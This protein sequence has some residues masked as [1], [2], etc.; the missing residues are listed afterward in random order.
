M[1]RKRISK[2][3]ANLL[4]SISVAVTSTIVMSA[5]FLCLSSFLKIDAQT[6]D[7]PWIFMGIGFLC[8]ALRQICYIYRA[9]NKSMK[10]DRI[11]NASVM[12]ILGL[13]NLIFQESPIVLTISTLVYLTT[14]IG[15]VALK[16][17]YHHTFSDIIFTLL[18][19][20]ILVLLFIASCASFK[21][22]QL[23]TAVTV[24]CIL[25]SLFSLTSII[26]EAF[27]KIQLSTIKNIIKKTFAGEILIGLVFLVVSFSFVFVVSE[28]MKFT[29]ALW[30]CFAVVTT[31]GFGDVTVKD[32]I[33]RIV[34][35]ILGAYGIVVVA[36]ITSII[37]NFYNETKLIN[38]QEDDEEEVE[39]KKEDPQEKEQESK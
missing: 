4:V 34:S 15:Y 13:I 6:V 7:A 3:K 8:A 33:S 23:A 36:L 27:A 5:F 12:V 19:E 38:K 11:V 22:E 10:I 18:N 31:I 17:V 28:G 29:D 14:L 16:V 9:E 25:M 26:R 20:G 37:V 24:L 21:E 2:D 39:E 1:A 35:V 30:Y 32:P